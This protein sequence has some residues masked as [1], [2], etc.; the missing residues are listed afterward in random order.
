[1]RL[2]L[3]LSAL[4]VL[5]A[6]TGDRTEPDNNPID[7]STTGQDTTPEDLGPDKCLLDNADGLLIEQR[8]TINFC[9]EGFEDCDADDS[10]G[11]EAAIE[12]SADNCGACG[13]QCGE[14][15]AC[16]G[17]LCKCG[18]SDGDGGP[19]CTGEGEVCCSDTCTQPTDP[20]CPCGEAANCEE[21]QLCCNDDC[22]EIVS[23]DLN[24]GACG[25]TCAPGQV[26]SEGE[27]AC[28][29]GLE[30]CDGDA[31]NGCEISL[32]DNNSN[33]GACGVTCGQGEACVDGACTCGPVVAT[34]GAIACAT[35]GQ[36]CCANTCVPEGDPRCACGN[37]PSC[38]PGT[39]CCDN[40]CTPIDTT[41][42][43][44]G[45][46]VACAPEQSCDEGACL[47]P[48]NS[49]TL[50]GEDC[51]N[52]D[53][54]EAHCGSCD[55]T[56]HPDRS[57]SS[58][59]CV[60][61]SNELSCT[62]GSCKTESAS[63]CGVCGRQCLSRIG[64]PATCQNSRCTCSLGVKGWGC[65]SNTD[66]IA[67]EVASSSA[68]LCYNSTRTCSSKTVGMACGDNALCVLTDI[69]SRTAECFTIC[70]TSLGGY[71]TSSHPDCPSTRD[72]CTSPGGKVSS[73]GYCK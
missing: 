53:T 65:P 70:R 47:C 30:N 73:Y 67:G 18:D 7:T 38:D 25:V 16:I 19:A 26:C 35:D 58:G 45:C 66:C 15:E 21:G 17:G 12:R 31:E 60:C 6:C 9:Y 62:D 1:M 28:D 68:D 41:T 44:G 23:D 42:D 71:G 4:L 54:E 33:C 63:N 14:G 49:P 20:T 64:I 10:T 24:C 50:C 57:C 46:G 48:S 40:L 13:V 56:C 61:P 11:C 36:V 3:F 8:C 22:A 29:T 69:F 72:I 5:S 55:N 37:A 51:V 32:L 43:C 52:T 27:C 34:D 2:T 39:V 59:N